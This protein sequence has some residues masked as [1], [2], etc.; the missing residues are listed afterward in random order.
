MGRPRLTDSD[1]GL[2]LDRQKR[3]FKEEQME[4]VILVIVAISFVLV[5]IGVWAVGGKE[6]H[7]DR[8][9]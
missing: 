5:V 2:G 9:E 8:D 3:R 7:L 1:W 6:I 4:T